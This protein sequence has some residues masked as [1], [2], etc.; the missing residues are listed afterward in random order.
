MMRFARICPKAIVLG[1]GLML[2]SFGCQRG[3]SS[4]TPAESKPAETKGK[5]A[6]EKAAAKPATA[7]DVLDRMVAAYQKAKTYSDQGSLRLQAEMGGQKIDQTSKFSVV[8]ERPNKLQVQAFQAML[9]CDG[10][11]M[12]AAINSIPNQI[13]VKPAPAKLD[14]KNVLQLDPNLTTRLS[15]FA[16]PPPQLFL[17]LAAD[18]MKTLLFDTEAPKLVESGEILGREC[19]RVQIKWPNGGGVLWIDQ[20]TFILRRIAFPT[21]DLRRNIGQGNPVESLSLVGEFTDAKFDAPIDPKLFAFDVPAGA[22]TVEVF[23]PP[24]PGQLLGKKAPAFK[25]QGLDDKP[26]TPETTADKVVVL[27][28]WAIGGE[29]CRQSL[30]DMENIRQKYKDNPKVAWYAVNIDPSQV[31]NEELT[32]LFNEWKVALPIVRDDGQTTAAFKIGEPPLTFM[33][34][35]FIIDAKGVVQ[36][37]ELA[38][39]PKLVDTLPT[40]LDKVLAGEDI[41]QEPLKMYLQELENLKKDAKSLNE[42][43]A[44]EQPIPQAKIAAKTEPATFKLT[45]LWKCTDLKLPGNIVVVGGKKGP[46]RFLVVENWKSVAE[47]G[48]DGKQIALHK[49]DD[50]TEQEYIGSLRTAVGADGKRYFAAFMTSQQRVHI[51][52]ENWKPVASYPEDALK[53][54]HGGISDAQL[55]DL[56]G[57]G[58]LKLYVGY[59]GVVGVQ[60][61][62]L[63]GHKLW[64]NRTDISS[65]SSLAIAPANAQG[66]S[67]LFCASDKGNIVVLDA[68]GAR[69]GEIAVRNRILRRILSADLLGDGHPLWCGLASARIGED[70]AV[71]FTASGEEQWSYPLPTGVHQPPVEPIVAGSIARDGAGQWLLSGAD[72]SIHVVSA[73]GK[74][75]DKFN[76]GAM[77][78]GLATTQIDGKPVLLVASPTGLEALRVE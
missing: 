69:R 5:P 60:A 53:N 61:A 68:K 73:E 57:D 32:K 10:H 25:L 4:K 41:F 21:D 42:G 39:N 75:V 78:Q 20:E 3:E 17:L 65:A 67:D 47:I 36:H 24:H 48:L 22:E 71:G 40:M 8:V 50:L 63:D 37:C 29:P 51:Y 54:P 64:A 72:G 70:T 18:P 9:A 56:D 28:F 6:D 27:N 77:L 1:L 46:E 59:W 30:T 58:K 26:V 19:Y 15:D 33:P 23:V 74:P 76:F 34:A 66:Q 55:G 12:R 38:G 35:V 7:R 49:L 11:E 13:L 14:I 16:G 44:M 2:V 45:P 31:K 43:V 52:D 62:S